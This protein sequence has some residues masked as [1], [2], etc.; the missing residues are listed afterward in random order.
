LCKRALRKSC[1]ANPGAGDIRQEASAIDL[2]TEADLLA[3]KH[4][5]PR[6]VESAISGLADHWRDGIGAGQVSG[7]G[8]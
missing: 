2:V 6:R 4:T 7:A 5:S 1:P 8:A 3:E